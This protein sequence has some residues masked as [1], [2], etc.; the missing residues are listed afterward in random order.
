MDT[1]IATPGRT[2]SAAKTAPLNGTSVIISLGLFAIGAFMIIELL[3]QLLFATGTG[4]LG[5]L[6]SIALSSMLTIGFRDHMREPET[7]AE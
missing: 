1:A 7:L 3:A 6:A 5:M 2:A 4:W